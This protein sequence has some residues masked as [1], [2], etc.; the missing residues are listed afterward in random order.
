MLLILN[1]KLSFLML[2]TLLLCRVWQYAIWPYLNSET[3]QR[4]WVFQHLINYSIM[5]DKL[6]NRKAEL[7]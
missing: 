4:S 5:P 6:S 3:P 1:T 2:C 7:S